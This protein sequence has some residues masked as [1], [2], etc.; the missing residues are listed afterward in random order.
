MFVPARLNWRLLAL[1]DGLPPA[2]LDV[3]TLL[4]VR[5]VGGVRG[6][7][8]L[9]RGDLRR[10]LRSNLG[11]E[12]LLKESLAQQV[13]TEQMQVEEMDA[14]LLPTGVV[15]QSGHTGLGVLLALNLLRELQQLRGGNV[16]QDLSQGLLIN[17]VERVL[18]I[19]FVM[20]ISRPLGRTGLDG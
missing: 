13:L 12:S 5:G 17:V 6:G 9:H 20:I 2:F 10:H 15:T 1:L 18:V 16:L 19:M 3:L 14:A 8:V 11:A 4:L 7:R